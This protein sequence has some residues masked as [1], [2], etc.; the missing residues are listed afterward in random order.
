MPFKPAARTREPATAMKPLVDPA[1]WTSQELAASTDWIYELS[2]AEQ[3][4]IRSAVARI[5]KQ[6]LS[7]LDIIRTD[8]PLPVFDAGLQMMYDEL[9]EGRGFCLIRG[10]P[11]ENFS[12]Q[13][14][15]IAFWGIGTRFGTALSQNIK[16][17]MLGHVKALGVSYTDQLVRGYQTADEMRFHSDQCDYVALLCLQPAKK[18]G[19]SRI[20]SA[21]TLYNELL[22]SD[23]DL[24]EELV[25]DFYFSKYNESKTGA[26]SW[27]KM[28]VFSFCDDYFTSRGIG[29]RIMK[30]QNIPDV[31]KFTERRQRAVEAYHAK[32]RKIYFDMDFQPGDIQIL[33]N[34]VTLHSRTA[35]EDWPEAARKRHLMRLWFGDDH[36][37]P[38]VP[39]FRK[40]LKG[41]V[42]KDAE[43]SAP[44]DNFEA[45]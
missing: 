7:I 26:P 22:K 5:E 8:F 40:E 14:A 24:V 35:F 33:H 20:A 2:P 18:G 12:K 45:V 16:G 37:R 21:V 25:K 3:D 28:P 41:I 42:V 29:A 43:L 44:I 6:N 1:G 38:T 39:G 13:Q 27:Y 9:L 34:H 19:A 23:P 17:H 4:D 30:A 10:V 31:P 15:A 11:V 32:V 36:G